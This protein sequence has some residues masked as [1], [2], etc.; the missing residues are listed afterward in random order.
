MPDGYYQWRIQEF[1]KGG[2]VKQKGGAVTIKIQYFGEKSL[3]SSMKSV[4]KGGAAAPTSSAV[5][6]PL[7]TTS[8]NRKT[9][10]TVDGNLANAVYAILSHLPM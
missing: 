10:A 8:T 2:A 5:D 4:S 3:E 1:L 9:Q 7:D 6:P